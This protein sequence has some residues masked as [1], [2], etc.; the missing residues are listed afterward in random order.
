MPDLLVEVRDRDIVISKPSAGLTITYRKVG[1]A[2]FLEALDPI[3]DNLN[4]DELIFPRACMEGHIRESEGAQVA[5]L[6]LL[7]TPI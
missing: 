5:E 2:P 7:A 3:R 6:I 4:S 1:D